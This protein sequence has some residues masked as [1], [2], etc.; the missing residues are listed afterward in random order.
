MIPFAADSVVIEVELL[1]SGDFV[2]DN[3]PALGTNET[4]ELDSINEN[5]RVMVNGESVLEVDVTFCENLTPQESGAGT[6]AT[7]TSTP[8]EAAAPDTNAGTSGT[9][10]LSLINAERARNG[11]GPVR[12]NDQLTVA[13]QRHSQDMVDRNYFDHIAPDPAPH[14][15]RPSNRV[16]AA[17]FQWTGVAENIAQGQQSEAEVF[18]SWMDSQ[19]HR[20]NMLNPTYDQIGLARVGDMWT[21]V[22][23]TGSSSSTGAS[24]NSTGT[25]N[26][27]NNTTGTTASDF[28]SLIN[29]ERARNGAGPVRFNDQLTVAAQRHSQDM[30]DRNYFDHVAPDPAPHGARP[31]NRVEAAG[32]QWTGVAENI[33]QGQQS[34]AEVFTSWMNSQGHRENMLNP[35]YDQIGLARVGDMWTLVLAKGG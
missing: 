3:L 24:G 13:A 29:A 5:Y 30:V 11:A 12:F 18:A 19:G 1:D 7:P 9:D 21:L 33:A 8:G 32:F 14:G 2:A 26:N 15:A 28:L 17:G 25:S 10:F 20:E 4:I 35:T 6:I 23:A 34:E 31:S 22:L 27:N 16:E